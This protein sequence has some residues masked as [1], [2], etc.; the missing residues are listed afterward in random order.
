M[1]I[2]KSKGLEFPV[3]IVPF[4]NWKAWP[5]RDFEIRQFQ[6]TRLVTPM[7][8]TLGKPY[9]TSMGRAVREQ[10]NLLYVAWTRSREELYGF[11]TENRRTPR[12]SPP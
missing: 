8:K 5:D 7:R 9:L 12:L 1:T 11:F 2:H 10:L 4:H 6:G 3:V